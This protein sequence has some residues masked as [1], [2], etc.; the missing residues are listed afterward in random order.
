MWKGETSLIYRELQIAELEIYKSKILDLFTET[1]I[2]NFHL[3]DNDA[4]KLCMGKIDSLEEYIRNN[5]AIV[6]GAIEDCVLI[7]VIWLYIHDYFGEKR[8]HVNQIAVDKNFRG[9]GIGKQLMQEA[10]K[11]AFKMGIA[12]IDL[13][14]SDLNKAALSLYDELGFKTE[15]RYMKKKLS[16][17]KI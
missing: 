8:L 15:R 3:N 11:Q 6:I 9:R 2:T 13:F 7:A 10:E 12:T 17:E 5:S 4:E 14:V 16:V 1:Y